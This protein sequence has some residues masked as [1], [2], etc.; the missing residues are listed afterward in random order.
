MAAAPLTALSS[1]NT[2]ALGKFLYTDY[3]YAFQSIG[4][5]LLVAMVG[6]IILTHR[7]R[8]DIKRQNSRDQIG[9]QRAEAVELHNPKIGQGAL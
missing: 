1:T 3:I 9:R 7:Q 2:Q 5:L 4:F 8:T 6:A